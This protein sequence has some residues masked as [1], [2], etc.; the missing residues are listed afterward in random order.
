MLSESNLEEGSGVVC[1]MPEW[2]DIQSPQYCILWISALA[3]MTD[4]IAISSRYPAG[5]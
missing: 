5:L 2:T 1:V 3:E 4:Y